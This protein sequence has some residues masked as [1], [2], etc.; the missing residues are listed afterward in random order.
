[1]KKLEKT[2]LTIT[3]SYFL[4]L[5]VAAI[6]LFSG[7][8]SFGMW[9]PLETK[10]VQLG[11]QV[12]NGE[13]SSAKSIRHGSG[14]L[15]G[16]RLSA[17][18]LKL[19]GRSAATA[20]LPMTVLVFASVLMIFFTLWKLV[21]L[22]VAALATLILSSAPV[23]LFNGRQATGDAPVLLG[24][25]LTLCGGALLLFGQGRMNAVLGV[26]AAV[27]GLV[28]GTVSAGLLYGIVAPAGT[29]LLTAALTGEMSTTSSVQDDRVALRRL[30]IV[31][32]ASL[33]F[34]SL[35]AFLYAAL[36]DVEDTF[37]ITGRLSA[38]RSNNTG[39][40]T[41]L[42][43]L[44]YGWFPWSAILPAAFVGVFGFVGAKSKFNELRL[45]ALSGIVVG[46]VAQTFFVSFHGS[47]PLFLALPVSLAVALVLLEMESDETP[48]LLGSIIGIVLAIIMIRDFSQRPEAIL[49]GFGVDKIKIPADFKPVFGAMFASIPFGLMLVLSGFV[50][51][52][53]SGR[54]AWRPF[55]VRSAVPVVAVTLAG[56]F[57]V[58]LVPGLSM[59][60]SSR[61]VVDSYRKYA[62]NSEPLTVL[63]RDKPQLDTV[64][65]GSY[66]E[67]VKWFGQSERVFA[68]I[69]PKS[70]SMFDRE[71]REKTG[72]HVF[73]P[74]AKSSRFFL[75]T[76]KKIKGVDNKNPISMFVFSKPFEIGDK[77]KKNIN[78]NNKTTLL[79]WK[80]ESVGG[81][82]RL[83][84]GSEFTLTTYWRCDD[85][86]PGSYKMFVHIDGPGPRIHGD[87]DMISDVYPTRDWRKGDYVKD[88]YKG[89]VPGFQK[90]GRYTIS[91]G[92]YK[93]S[94][95]L[96]ILDE[97]EA[98]QDSIRLGKVTLK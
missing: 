28:I 56:Y 25:T 72:R 61:H 26:V 49:A 51:A 86:L 71:H 55:R 40:A 62:V 53:V 8:S 73:V 50:G 36:L 87:H 31:I 74:D 32:F 45:L 65:V 42:E 58:F 6:I 95:R 9:E 57:T 33:S 34:L 83:K 69:P 85:K 91:V 82:N 81:G 19:G 10:S 24:E 97:P 93:G 94:T 2:K 12:I 79:G 67:I 60:L 18:G 47:A 11:E 84:A 59:D 5:L 29:L 68:L 54:S 43:Q 39:S 3:V 37:W 21:G 52:G 16:Q 89:S 44:A 48:R 1:M 92:L 77:N 46:I 96:K 22:D 76:N 14:L 30:L 64:E 38:A 70:F 80:I 35:G 41:V 75:T 17:L 63:G 27:L 20:R 88:V 4:T 23:I 15:V 66:K 7:L 98:K 78:F 13:V 90:S